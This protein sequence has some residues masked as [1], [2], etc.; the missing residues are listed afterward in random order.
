MQEAVTQAPPPPPP[1]T[2]IPQGSNLPLGGELT[3]LQASQLRSRRS[4]LSDQ[5]IS[6]TNRR[7]E[8]V[9]QLAGT[10]GPV[11]QGLIDRITVLD[12][13]IVRIE[14]DIAE[15]G[16]ILTDN[17]IQTR[18]TQQQPSTSPIEGLSQGGFIG[19]SVVTIVLVLFPI[20][21]ACSR[22]IWRRARV[23]APPRNHDA[24]A[25]LERIEEAVDAIA[26]EIERVSEAQRFSA[27]L[28]S[29]GAAQPI[30]QGS[31]ARVEAPDFVSAR[32]GLR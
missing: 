3:R 12:E 16:R 28:L 1:P 23:P 22:W 17:A 27:R 30:S 7:E 9:A 15:T 32:G 25:R 5:L 10:E 31:G 18:E 2:P 19:I 11:R 26:I 20:S 24:D 29:E 21:I 4:E 13:R 6:A 14:K 8:L